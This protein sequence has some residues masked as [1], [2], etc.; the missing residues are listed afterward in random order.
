MIISSFLISGNRFNVNFL[1]LDW[2]SA[3]S[4]ALVCDKLFDRLPIW[5]GAFVLVA[6]EYIDIVMEVFSESL[7]LMFDI[8]FMA[9]DD[10]Q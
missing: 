8:T 3:A 9:D 10:V 5:Y 6:S 7:N 2:L 4:K 1:L